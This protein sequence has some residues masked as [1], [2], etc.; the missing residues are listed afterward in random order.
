MS[1][2]N[3]LLT[4]TE[5]ARAVDVSRPILSKCASVFDLLPWH[6]NPDKDNTRRYYRLS[7]V[8]R[9]LKALEP[10]RAKEIPLKLCRAELMRNAWYKEMR[11]REP[12]AI[13][14]A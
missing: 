7:E 5:L 6:P 11:D 8:R 3:D 1:K 10:L 2:A 14:E 4:L 12:A 13:T 9:V